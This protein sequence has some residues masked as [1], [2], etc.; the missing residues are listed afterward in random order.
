MLDKLKQFTNLLNSKGIPVPLVKDPKTGMG[1]VSLT[2]VFLSSLYVQVGL[3]GKYSK[4][5]D[6]IDMTQALNFFM[7]SAGLY[8]GRNLSTNNGKINV[9]PT[10]KDNNNDQQT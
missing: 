2:L 10:D 3:I 7:I 1:S 4:L 5:L 9:T 8:F 6:G